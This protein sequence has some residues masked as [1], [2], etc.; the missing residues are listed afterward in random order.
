MLGDSGV[1]ILKFFLHVSKK[2]QLERLKVRLDDPAKHWKANPQD[3][4]ERRFWDD[5]MDAYEAALRRCSTTHAPW[6]VIPADKK[7]FRN[8]AISQILLDELES[9][10]MKFPEGSCDIKSIVIE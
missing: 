8:L 9:L 7:W 1:T 3:F 10:N 5:Y 4:D 6:F 2:E